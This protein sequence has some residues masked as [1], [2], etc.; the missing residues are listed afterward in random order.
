MDMT[1]KV[2]DAF[3]GLHLIGAVYSDAMIRVSPF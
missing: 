3:R 1:T 2:I